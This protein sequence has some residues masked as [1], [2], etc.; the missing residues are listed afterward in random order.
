[1]ASAQRTAPALV[2]AWGLEAVLV[3]E[4][5]M[6][7]AEALVA[8]SGSTW[9]VASVLGLAWAS[10]LATALALDEGEP[11]WPEWRCRPMHFSGS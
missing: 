4:L 2:R 11:D 10:E 9:A 7:W 6:A 3:P 8:A 5:A 1:V